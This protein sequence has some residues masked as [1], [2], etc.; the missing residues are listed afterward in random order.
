[1]VLSDVHIRSEITEK[2]LVFD[3]PIDLKSDRIDRSAVDLLLHDELIILPKG[4]V[5]GV[6]IDPNTIAN[7]AMDVLNR[8]GTQHRLTTDGPHPLAP[9]HLIIGKT[10]ERIQLPRHLVERNL[11]NDGLLK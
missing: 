7:G 5:G 2:R 6:I 8:H 9:H 4:P 10:L 1:M 3:P 11:C